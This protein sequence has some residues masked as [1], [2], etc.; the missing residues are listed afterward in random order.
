MFIYQVTVVAFALGPGVCLATG[1][2]PGIN[3]ICGAQKV[4][5][6]RKWLLTPMTFLPL[7]SSMSR[8]ARP[9]TALAWRVPSWI[10]L[11]IPLVVGVEPSG[12][13]KAN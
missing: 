8:L 6:I 4:K 9:L 10:R 12:T 11:A 7:L 3:A 2:G 5:Q 13:K 1:L